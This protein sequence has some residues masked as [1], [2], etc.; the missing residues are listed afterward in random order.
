MTYFNHRASN[1]IANLRGVPE[2][3]KYQLLRKT[4]SIKYSIDNILKKYN[5]GSQSVE[6]TLM[7]Q[8]RSIVGEQTAHRCRP[9]KILPDNRLIIIT[10]N[11][12]LRQE[13]EF[14]KCTILK[15]I[16]SLPD[17]KHIKGIVF[18]NG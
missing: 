13:L 11:A 10:S 3:N 6:D 9:H 16:Q 14:K 8:W 4:K 17:C 5:I 12:I 7:S 2:S 18:S 1:L 15:K